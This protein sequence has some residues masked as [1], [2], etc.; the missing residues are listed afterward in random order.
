MVIYNHMIPTILI[1]FLLYVLLI[2][3]AGADEEDDSS[4]DYDDPNPGY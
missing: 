4:H 1:I 2:K 3:L